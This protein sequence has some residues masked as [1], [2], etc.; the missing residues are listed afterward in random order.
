MITRTKGT[1]EKKVHEYFNKVVETGE[2]II[3]TSNMN[4]ILKIIPIKKKK[5]AAD[6][7]ADVR[8]KV[9]YYSDILEPEI[10]EWGVL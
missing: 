7:F 2:E 5:D 9:K 6:V 4:P 3:V 1:I 10:E 8:G